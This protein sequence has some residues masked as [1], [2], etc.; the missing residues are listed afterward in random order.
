MS[1][2]NLVD[3]RDTIAA[4]SIVVPKPSKASDDV[5]HERCYDLAVIITFCVGNNASIRKR[6]LRELLKVEVR[7]ARKGRI[8]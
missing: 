3:F 2:C 1:I 7:F 4:S 6:G 5:H 8:P